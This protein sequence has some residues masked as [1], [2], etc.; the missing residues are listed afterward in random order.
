MQ[1]I[2][3]PT[4]FSVTAK[5]AALYAIQL[6]EDLGVKRVVVYHAYQ[7][8]VSVDPMM[9]TLQM[10]DLEEFKKISETGLDRFV[11]EIKASISTPVIIEAVNE[12]NVLD[13]GIEQICERL[14][15]GLIIM[16]ITGGGKVEE[17][18][19]GSNTTDIAKK[20]KT[21]VII[22]PAECKYTP[23]QEIVLACD[24]KKVVE[25][26]PVEPIKNLLD[27]T[28]AKLYVLN[29]SDSKNPVTADAS[30]ESLMVET[31][32]ESYH[33]D[34]HFL[35]GDDFTEVINQFATKHEVDLII[36]IPKKHG[37]FDQLFRRSHTK[38]L[39]FHSHVPLMVVHE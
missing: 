25:T 39:A 21:P 1:T 10:M 34:Y 29:V 4:D 31:L 17:V 30:Y 7:L 12:F 11:H 32:F 13:I 18:L 26:T 22:I 35:E 37:L 2:L 3:V 5:N 33:P 14:H 20:S 24:L 16:G 27:K 6:A 38:M 23:L 15:P 8:P 9:P 36:T 19:I 28:K